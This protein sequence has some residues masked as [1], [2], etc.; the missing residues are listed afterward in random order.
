MSGFSTENTMTSSTNNTSKPQTEIA[1]V[2][3]APNERAARRL[4]APP[5]W[6]AVDFPPAAAAVSVATVR[7]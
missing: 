5:R 2:S 6:Q 4:M 7:A 3:A 1:R